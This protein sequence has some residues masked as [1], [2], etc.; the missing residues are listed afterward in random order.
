MEFKYQYALTSV[1][2]DSSYENAFRFDTRAQQ[3]AYFGTS[4]L[5]NNAKSVNFDF[6]NLVRTTIVI[7]ERRSP[8]ELMGY[9]YL[10]VKDNNEGAARRYVY[11]LSLIH[12]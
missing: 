2:F 10:I 1:P 5:F 9:N 8:L 3:E 12:I 7:R 6:G 11:Y 4:T